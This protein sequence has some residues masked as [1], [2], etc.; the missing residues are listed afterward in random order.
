MLRGFVEHEA[1]IFPRLLHLAP[2][3]SK[4]I[5][6]N[7]IIVI[8]VI[9]SIIIVIIINININI[10]IDINIIIIDITIIIIIMIIIILIFIPITIFSNFSVLFFLLQFIDI[11]GKAIIEISGLRDMLQNIL[12]NKTQATFAEHLRTSLYRLSCD[13]T[14]ILSI[15]REHILSF[16]PYHPWLHLFFS[17]SQ[18]ILYGFYQKYFDASSNIS[19]LESGYLTNKMK[20]SKS[21]NGSEI[22]ADNNTETKNISK[23]FFRGFREDFTVLQELDNNRRLKNFLAAS[24]R[25]KI[26]QRNILDDYKTTRIQFVW[27]QKVLVDAIKK[28][29]SESNLGVFIENEILLN[30]RKNSLIGID[31][32]LSLK[33]IFESEKLNRNNSQEEKVNSENDF[34]YFNHDLGSDVAGE[35][36][37][38]IYQLK[39][40]K[41]NDSAANNNDY[42][43]KNGD[44]VKTNIEKEK[45]KEKERDKE[46][47]N[48]QNLLIS[49]AAA[50]QEESLLLSWKN[51][52]PRGAYLHR[53]SVLT[54][55]F[56][57]F[58]TVLLAQEK[59]PF[60]IFSFVNRN[61]AVVFTYLYECF[62]IIWN[63]LCYFIFTLNMKIYGSTTGEKFQNYYFISFY[64]IIYY[65]VHCFIIVKHLQ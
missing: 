65:R 26:S 34:G 24:A 57:S 56:Y 10:N 59:N 13:F 6:F 44:N 64:F 54:D 39:K 29:L 62:H 38:K 16:S 48:E 31:I 19:D 53:L 17:G 33:T 21:W 11:A 37:D 7:C 63:S 8:M 36:F 4:V 40:N 12:N 9:T 45:E 46:V 18:K 50:I 23:N 35:N 61:M 30:S 42:E 49:E 41:T 47:E 5:V 28:R 60:T 2:A 32:E 55:L 22:F 14:A 15:I 52:S 25:L 51:L 58:E 43:S 27:R 20:K 1:I 3:I